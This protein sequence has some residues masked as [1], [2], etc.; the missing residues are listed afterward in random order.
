MSLR[1]YHLHVR[2]QVQGVGFRPFVYRLALAHGLSG[3]VNNAV[4][5]VHIEVN[6]LENQVQD[7]EA[8]LLNEAPP[9]ARVTRL[10]KWV[11]PLK[12][13]SGFDIHDSPTE[14]EPDLLLTPD[15]A[16]CGDC[17]QE[18]ETVHD[19]RFGYAFL[20]CTYCG[21]RYSIEH[22]LPYDRERTSMAVFT[23]CATCNA[24]YHDLN[25]RRYFS[26]T[27]SCPECGV[28]LKADDTPDPLQA[29]LT[30]LSTGKI[31]AVKGIGGWLLL[32]DA[33]DAGA[34]S[35]LRKRKHRPT[36]P[37]AVLYPDEA[38]LA[39]DTELHPAAQA[40]LNGSESPIVLLPLKAHPASG[41]AVDHLAPN[42]DHLGVMLPYAPLLHLLANGFGKPLVATSGNLS[43]SPIAYTDQQAH[44]YLAGIA[45]FFLGNDRAIVTPQDDSLVRFS[46]LFHRP[47]MLRRS[48]GYAPTLLPA[49][50]PASGNV[51]AL[52]ADLKAAFAWHYKGNCYVSQ[53]LGDLASYDSQEQ[54]R[55]VVD[56]F[57][58]LLKATPD[59]I[60]IDAHPGYFSHTL[61]R[62]LAQATGAS[63]SVQ[64]HHE[65]HFAAVMAENELFGETEPVLGVIW[66]GTGYGRDGNLW[67]GEFF[68]YENE[69]IS[70]IAH[71]EP[72]MVLG[73]DQMALQ[74][75]LS[76]LSL[77]WE[78]P[79]VSALIKPHFSENAWNLYQSLLAR[80]GGL[81]TSSMGR[82]FDAVA[83][84][85]GAG[86]ENYFEGES[87]MR[88]EAMASAWVKI[89]GPEVLGQDRLFPPSL[90]PVAWLQSVAIALG[91]GLSSGEIAARFI[92][93]LTEVVAWLAE[94]KGFRSLAFS[95]GVFQNGLLRDLLELR[96][97][98]Q[99]QLFFH[100][101]L[102]P[103]DECIGY[104]Q[105]ALHTLYQQPSIQP[106]YVSGN[107]R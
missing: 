9:L 30:A 39:L 36:K 84:L 25:D 44:A 24:E 15:M 66:D 37:L 28:S 2:G 75:R 27:N 76:A 42:L 71:L 7:F 1:T 18:L 79:E 87:A 74:P 6:A 82:V 67:G 89:H 68:A 41:I 80:T 77:G 11:L 64:Y 88:L 103:N 107:S 85:L 43:G 105:L 58:Q 65:A 96:L 81:R 5:G 20:T 47:I 90:D 49:R 12:D 97:G 98:G 55:V 16:L 32:C 21:P 78:S 54:F 99:F 33:T 69:T 83:A 22:A 63:L 50:L 51:L 100:Q 86:A 29:A 106:A 73:G 17:R 10:E 95:G 14:G 34:I 91:Q 70:R 93:G 62:E 92:Y 102:S 19:R 31:V 104:G 40:L 46:P 8:A 35:A 26:Q 38:M 72:F 4:D 3:W 45:D 60:I 57:Q 56:H 52:G 59:Q 13:F 23:P 94:A 61:G 101:Q 48:R 53:F